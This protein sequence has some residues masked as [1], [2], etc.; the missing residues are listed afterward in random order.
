MTRFRNN[1]VKRRK[2]N[3]LEAD[4]HC[5]W[6]GCEVFAY[7]EEEMQGKGRRPDD[8]ATVDHLNMRVNGVRVNFGGGTRIVTV[9]SCLGCNVKR[10]WEGSEG[11]KWTKG[12]RVPNPLQAFPLPAILVVQPGPAAD[13]RRA[14]GRI[15]R[16]H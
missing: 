7:P 16:V 10:A 3:L 14:H 13:A 6:C 8:L 4:P 5:Y 12:C 9:L 11:S 1:T 15:F 2:F